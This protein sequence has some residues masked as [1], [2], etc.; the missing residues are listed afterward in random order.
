MTAFRRS[1]PARISPGSNPNAAQAR[2][3]VGGL[4]YAVGDLHGRLDCFEAMI[5]LIRADVATL[6]LGEEKPTIVLLGDLIDRGPAS[7]GCVERAIGLAR[8]GWCDVEMLK[9]NHE[10]AL[11]QFLDDPGVGPAWIQYGGA[12]TLRSYGVDV[13]R[14]DPSKGWAGVQA[15]FAEALPPA[16]RQ[17]MEDMKLWLRR[18][19]YLFVHAGVRPGVGIEQQTEADLLWIR[20]EFSRVECPYPGK[21]VV[22]GH[23]PHREPELHRWRIGLDTGAYQTGV[24]TA[25]RLRG[26]ERVLIQVR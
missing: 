22:H 21:V 5:A 8:E 16:H 7:A 23:T 13:N 9:G 3:R 19:D 14:V 26:S 18:G 17:C 12:D 25:I 11:L 24:L 20:Q 10:Q 4:V 6:A 2:P 1:P 15:A